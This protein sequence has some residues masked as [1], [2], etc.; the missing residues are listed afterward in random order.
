LNGVKVEGVPEFVVNVSANGQLSSTKVPMSYEKESIQRLA[1]AS[2]ATVTELKNLPNTLAI[3]AKSPEEVLSAIKAANKTNKNTRESMNVFPANSAALPVPD[4]VPE[5]ES[6]P[7]AESELN[8]IGNATES[9][10]VAPLEVSYKYGSVSPMAATSPM[11]SLKNMMAVPGQKGGA[12]V[13][14]HQQPQPYQ[15]PEHP[16]V[17]IANIPMRK[18]RSMKMMKVRGKYSKVAK[19]IRNYEM[20]LGN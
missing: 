14:S 19:A 11:A 12:T 7:T 9:D 8:A 17:F 18:G 6:E 2:S 20:S 4:I 15:D 1:N 5:F 13:F 16:G 3:S 10:D